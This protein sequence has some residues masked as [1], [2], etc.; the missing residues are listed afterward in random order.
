MA[1]L[2]QI[3]ANRVNAQKST[4][5]KTPEGKAKV[6][7]NALKHG[8][9]SQD[10][11]LPGEDPNGD[12]PQLRESLTEEWQPES[13]TEQFLVETLAGAMWK[14]MR[15]QRIQKGAWTRL[16]RLDYEREEADKPKTANPG[17]QGTRNLA[18]HFPYLS[19]RHDRHEAHLHRLVEKS[20]RQLRQ[21]RAERPP[22]PEPRDVTSNPIAPEIQQNDN[23]PRT[24]APVVPITPAPPPQPEQG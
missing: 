8:F 20:I 14:L 19:D 24:Q 9:F 10:V 13:A 18:E 17:D 6:S 7:K 16:L 15:A 11:V 4:G 1:S 3:A 22:E 23:L 2:K 12:F 21:L 5:P